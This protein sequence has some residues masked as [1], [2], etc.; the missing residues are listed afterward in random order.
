MA[1]RINAVHQIQLRLT[2]EI[3]SSRMVRLLLI[4]FVLTSAPIAPVYADA[5]SENIARI[6]YGV[7]HVST[8]PA[9]VGQ[10]V[11]IYA[12][13][14][15]KAHGN[16]NAPKP[17]SEVVVFVH[18]GTV[19][20]VPDYDLQF[21]DYSWAEFLARAGYDV[22]M[23]DQTGY[24]FSPRPTMN[25]PC[26]ANPAQQALLIPNP[27]AAPCTP[28]PSG[29]TSTASDVDEINSVVDFVRSLRGVVRVNLIGWSTGGV[30]TGAYAAQYPEKVN[31]MVFLAAGVFTVPAAPFPMSLQNSS[32]IFGGRWDSEVR[33]ANQF[34]PA[35]RPV[36]WAT[37]MSFD[38]RG[39]TWGTPEYNPVAS[40]T[41]GLMRG[42]QINYRFTAAQAGEIQ[43]PSLV[44][45]G[46]FDAGLGLSRNLYSVLGTQNKVRVE[47][48]C[49]SH[50]L[51]YERQH[52]VL[53]DATKAW[54]QTGM[55]RGVQ[56]GVFTVDASGK[57]H[58]Q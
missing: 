11:R 40:P 2:E 29:L 5:Q 30:R 53:L 25:D 50:F 56:Q 15:F 28:I 14:V 46:E 47:V 45:V 3:M 10:S 35:I 24:G 38:P 37:I 26:N 58:Q 42:P 22:F 9:N 39:S 27:L 32:A 6:E 55:I 54:L 48:G 7:P 31:K 44:I 57:Y 21:Q 16:A 4:V 33:C 43:A 23:L 8:V 13:E 49:A 1:H 52:H 19:P 18:G 36:I 41:G 17:G 34:D 20:S 51:P 12:R